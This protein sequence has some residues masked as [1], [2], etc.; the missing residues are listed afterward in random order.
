MMHS[1][2]IKTSITLIFLVFIFAIFP[3]CHH[4]SLVIDDLDTVCFYDQVFPVLQTSCG[5]AGCHD[6]SQEGFLASNYNSIMQSVVPGDPRG[7]RLYQVIT[8][9]NGEGMMPPDRPLTKDQRSVIQVW[10]AQGALE[11]TCDTGIGGESIIIPSDTVCFVQDMLPLFISNCAMSSCHDGLSQ[12]EENLFA[13]N[14]YSTI[15]AHAVPFNPSQSPVYKAVTGG[16]EEFMPP[17]PKSPLTTAQKELMRKWIADGALNSDCPDVSCDTLNP[18]GFAAQVKPIID[19]YCVSCHN[20]SSSS[21]GVNLNGYAQ[22]KKIAETYRNGIPLLVGTIRHKTGFKAMP[23]SSTL[24]E[25]N[26]RKIELWIEQGKP[27]N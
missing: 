7:S 12:G 4:D 24:D 1:V 20:A 10:I 23:P 27:N 8:D 25:C 15:R 22:V 17:E 18:I 5:I 16:G 6:G 26:M 3:A 11:T 14:S 13:L 2:V 19:G 9:I 21:G